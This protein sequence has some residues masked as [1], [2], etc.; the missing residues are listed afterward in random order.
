MLQ[1][2]EVG[3]LLLFSAEKN[4]EGQTSGELIAEGAMKDAHQTLIAEL[5][6]EHAS[7]GGWTGKLVTG[8][9]TGAEAASGQEKSATVPPSPHRP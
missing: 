6:I 8:E 5:K 3:F 4:A 1:P 9:T 7:A 2:R